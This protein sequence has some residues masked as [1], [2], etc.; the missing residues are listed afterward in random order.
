MT[1]L[2]WLLTGIAWAAT[3]MIAL[4]E[5]NYQDPETILDWTVTMMS[6]GRPSLD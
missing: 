3:S 4:A 2:I 5:T 1:R 6:D